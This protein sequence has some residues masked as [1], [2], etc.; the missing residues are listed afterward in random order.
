[1]TDYFLDTGQKI[2]IEREYDGAIR[3]SVIAEITAYGHG[4]NFSAL[5]SV[6]ENYAV[7]RLQK[8]VNSARRGLIRTGY[9]D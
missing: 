2:T 8:L 6:S 7:E 9:P 1:M 4:P 3:A 5:T